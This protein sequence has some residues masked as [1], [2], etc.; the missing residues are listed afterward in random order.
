VRITFTLAAE[1]W[2]YGFKQTH[3]WNENHDKGN[4]FCFHPNNPKS[5]KIAFPY[6]DARFLIS[7]AHPNRRYI[8][9]KNNEVILN[10]FYTEVILLLS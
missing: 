6:L 3:G 9:E 1:A 4:C 10:F 8:D 7:T 2:N 5:F